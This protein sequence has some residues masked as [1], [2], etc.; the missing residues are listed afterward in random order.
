MSASVI[1]ASSTEEL[2]AGFRAHKLSRTQV[3]AALVAAGATAGG[4]AVLVNAV[5]ASPSTPPSHHVASATANHAQV[6]A[7]AAHQR[8]VA[9]QTGR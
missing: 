3:L 8:H 4:A 7:A 9:L 2:I 6:S 5:Q 1:A